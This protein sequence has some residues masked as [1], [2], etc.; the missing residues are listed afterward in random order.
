MV[1]IVDAKKRYMQYAQAFS[2]Q[3]AAKLPAHKPWDYTINLKDPNTK[4]P[5][6][7]IYKMT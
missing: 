5:N 1:L 7:S 3:Q 2:T 6:S 4:V